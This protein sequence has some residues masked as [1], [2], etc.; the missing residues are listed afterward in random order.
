[1]LAHPY[2]LDIEDLPTSQEDPDAEDAV[3]PITAADMVDAMESRHL[4]ENLLRS[5]GREPAKAAERP[6]A[7]S[8]DD[9]NDE[10]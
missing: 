9:F 2:M 1:L 10:G 7:I 3:Q 5:A 6:I 4:T 8:A